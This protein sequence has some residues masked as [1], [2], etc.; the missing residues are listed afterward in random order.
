MHLIEYIIIPDSV[1]RIGGDAFTECSLLTQ[2][3]CNNSDLFTDD[4]IDNRDQIQFISTTDYLK[5]N[6][7]DLLKAIKNSWFN[8]YH[9]SSKELNLIMKLHQKDFLP[10]WETLATTF[11]ERFIDQIRTILNYFN[12]NSCIPLFRKIHIT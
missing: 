8:T 5:Q 4:N 1:T 6:Y 9:V 7:Q 10:D 12:K 2:I 11:N 3:I